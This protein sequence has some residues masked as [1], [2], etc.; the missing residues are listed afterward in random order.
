M[1]AKLLDGSLDVAIALTEGLLAGIAKGHDAYKIVGTYVES[2][3]CRS[4]SLYS[5]PLRNLIFVCFHSSIQ[6]KIVY[7]PA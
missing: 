2:P 5:P 1:T 6:R 7:T 3:L 4:F